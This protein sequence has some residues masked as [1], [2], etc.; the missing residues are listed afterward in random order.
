M[1]RK[2][3]KAA[4]ALSKRVLRDIRHGKHDV[5]RDMRIAVRRSALAGAGSALTLLGMLAMFSA[6]VARGVSSARRRSLLIV[7]GASS[8]LGALS[9]ASARKALRHLDVN[10]RKATERVKHA[11]STASRAFS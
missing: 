1:D 11:L 10:P 5:E 3:K 9:F 8:A 4:R 7:S 2:I 6:G